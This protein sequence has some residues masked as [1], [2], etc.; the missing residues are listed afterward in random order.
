M[1]EIDS[2]YS[3]LTT[4]REFS[5]LAQTL[6]KAEYIAVD[7]EFDRFR[8]RYGFNLCLMQLYDGNRCYLL[9]PIANNADISSIFPLIE[10]PDILK[11]AF[12]FGEDLR[13]LHHL[14]CKPRNVYDLSIAA[15]LLDHEPMSLSNLLE[16][17]L[18]VDL[19][20]SSQQSNWIRRP[21]SE[22][23]L[24]YAAHDVLHLPVL[25]EQFQRETANA[26][27][28]D[29]VKQENEHFFSFNYEDEDHK[30]VLREKDKGNLTEKEWK[31]F[32]KL[33]EMVNEYALSMDR[34]PFQIADKEVMRRLSQSPDDIDIW[35]SE[36][37]I[38]RRLKSD[39][40][41]S[42]LK[43]VLLVAQKEAKE[44]GLSDQKKARSRMSPEEYKQYQQEQQQIAHHKKILY[45]PIQ[46]YLADTLGNNAQSFIL[47]NRLITELVTGNAENLLPYKRVIFNEAIQKLGLESQW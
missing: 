15:S 16:K 36:K 6:K 35:I 46:K 18:A 12:S 43:K 27:I 1:S 7:L 11:I 47:N 45:K 37:R 41:I 28:N 39:H 20:K 44:E 31:I 23:Q 8:Y 25:Y 33:S 14:G 30:P 3:L 21:L 5:D 2:S 34:P 40:A 32:T 22:Q 29:W 10:D 24:R 26:G 42:N 17:V 13:L 4:E 19:P 9:D 38:H